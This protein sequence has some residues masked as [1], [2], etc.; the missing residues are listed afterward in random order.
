[1]YL[2]GGIKYKFSQPVY[3]SSVCTSFRP[4]EAQINGPRNSHCVQSMMFKKDKR[5][6]KTPK[7]HEVL[8]VTQRI[9][10]LPFL[11]SK[12]RQLCSIDLIEVIALC[13]CT[14]ID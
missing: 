10:S 8:Q 3:T 6:N 14:C 4:V 13:G 5:Q 1:M 2:G 12:M 7:Y 11:L 9:L